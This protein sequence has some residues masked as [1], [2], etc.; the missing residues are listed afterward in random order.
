VADMRSAFKPT[1]D[2]IHRNG[3]IFRWAIVSLFTVAIASWCLHLFYVFLAV[4]LVLAVGFVG[5]LIWGIFGAKLH[6]PNCNGQ[7]L[8]RLGPY[9]PECA[10][11][12]LSEGSWYTLP[13]C[14]SC[15][16]V[17]ERGK[18]RR[19]RVRACTHCGS[20]LDDIGI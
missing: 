8:S 14:W 12:S 13:Q 16:T 2:R 3:R 6:C 4:W 10:A 5:L 1:A 7:L 15:G 20:R 18:G 17:M 9:C 19:Y 11:R